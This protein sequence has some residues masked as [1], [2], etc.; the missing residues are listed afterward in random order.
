MYKKNQKILHFPLFMNKVIFYIFAIIL[1]FPLIV[2]FINYIN[3]LFKTKDENVINGIVGNISK[4]HFIPLLYVAVLFINGESTDKN[5]GINDTQY[6]F[7]IFY[8]F[9]NFTFHDIYLNLYKNRF[10]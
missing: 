2:A 6:F 9:N 8:N 3:N 1:L 5:E 4:L 7:S 10:T